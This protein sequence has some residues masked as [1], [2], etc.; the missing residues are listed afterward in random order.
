MHTYIYLTVIPQ[1]SVGYKMIGSCNHL[2]SNK[3]EELF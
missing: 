2:I 1:A 3:K